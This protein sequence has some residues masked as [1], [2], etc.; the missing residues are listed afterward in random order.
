MRARSGLRLSPGAKVSLRS[1]CTLC[2]TVLDD[3]IFS[4]DATFSKGAGGVSQARYASR[5]GVR[6]SGQARVLNLR[7]SP[8]AG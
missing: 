3:A 1:C 4:N 6:R 8:L 7:V 5:G 2:G